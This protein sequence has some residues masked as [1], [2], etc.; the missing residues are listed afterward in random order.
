MRRKTR[1]SFSQYLFSLDLISGLLA[2]LIILIG[3]IVTIRITR[4]SY[5][6]IRLSEA[7]RVHIIL[8]KR[9]SE[10]QQN[11]EKLS[12]YLNE[13]NSKDVV[14]MFADFS[15][16]YR[17]DKEFKIETIYLKSPKSKIF[18]GFSFNNERFLEYLNEVSDN[19]VFS[20]VMPGLEDNEPGIYYLTFCESNLYLFRLNLSYINDYLQ[21][22]SELSETPIILTSNDGFVMASS[23][24]ELDIYSFDLKKWEN[25]IYDG[26]IKSSDSLKWIP[27]MSSADIIGAKIVIL[28]PTKVTD[29]LEQILFVFYLIFFFIM[30]SLIFAKNH[31][32]R[33][34]VLIPLNLFADKMEEVTDG[35]YGIIA[36]NEDYLFKE[37]S[38]FHNH[39]KTMSE[40]IVE[41][42]ESLRNS[43][44]IANELVVKADSANKAKSEFLANMSH[45]IRTPMNAVLGFSE[46]IYQ[47]TTNRKHKDYLRTIINSGNALLSIINDILDI[48][49]IEAGKIEISVEHV[50]LIDLIM[51][52]KMF[53]Q[54][55]VAEKK[56][57]FLINIDENFPPIVMID[58]L[59]M[60]QL[61]LNLLSNAVKFT[62]KGSIITQ[63]KVDKWNKEETKIDFSI[64]VTDSGIGIPENQQNRIFEAFVQQSGQDNRTYG[65]TGLGLTISKKLIE[66]MGGEIDLKSKPDVGSTFTLKLYSVE[67]ELVGNLSKSDVIESS[68]SV[69]FE[70]QTILVVD[71]VQSNRDLIVSYLENSGLEVIAVEN[72]EHLSDIMNRIKIDLILMDLHMPGKDGYEIT[73]FIRE[74]SDNFK[75]PIIA[76]TATMFEKVEETSHGLFDGFLRKPVRKSQVFDELKKFLKYNVIKPV[77]SEQSEPEVYINDL[78]SVSESVRIEFEERFLKQV[79]DLILLMNTERILEFTESVTYFAEMNNISELKRICTEINMAVDSF[80]FDRVEHILFLMKTAILPQNKR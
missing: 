5:L 54:T 70:K 75:I 50:S 55:K 34:F 52:L 17:L 71:D 44:I 68:E 74:N 24:P 42:E 16:L 28:I 19:R 36:S 21:K 66:L 26:V 58:E 14:S 57:E 9:L 30:I 69:L 8:E 79:D 80:E 47:E 45:E 38:N 29:M 27:V 12:S 65:G 59:R 37:L 77:N 56:L 62:H 13:G 60:R 35:N 4:Q 63:V 25:N 31:L 46:V 7:E 51:N 6:N 67:Y 32:F 15:D 18:E 48:S 49:K 3:L 61:L 10:Y 53:F 23:N 1:I 73:R 2:S 40:A 20:N 43:E 64:E 76:F 11:M 72:G 33:R 41:R 22:I 78:Q 39:F